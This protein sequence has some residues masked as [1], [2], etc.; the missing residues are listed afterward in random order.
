MYPILRPILNRG[1]AGRSLSREDTNAA[2]NPLIDA[3]GRL[4]IAYHEAIRTLGNRVHAQQIEAVTNRL[5]TELGKLKETVLANGGVPPNGVGL[6]DKP[7][8]LGSNDGEILRS[9]ER[10]EREYRD[11]LREVLDYSH[12]QIRTIAIV[13]NNV[14]GSNERIGVLRPLVDRTPSRSSSSSAA[15][16]DESTELP[17]DLKRTEQSADHGSQPAAHR[18][19]KSE[20]DN[21]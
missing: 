21:S 7:I 6:R 20:S 14:T 10:I 5:R 16:V 4:I 13:E 2:L 12:H 19:E 15:P 9:L 8:D 11:A 17:S 3:H 18:A 1:G